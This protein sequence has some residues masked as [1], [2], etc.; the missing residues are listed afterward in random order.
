MLL[1]RYSAQSV[2]CHTEH[3]VFKVLGLAYKEPWNRNT[4][5]NA[6]ITAPDLALD[7]AATVLPAP[8][9]VPIPTITAPTSTDD[10]PSPSSSSITATTAAT[11]K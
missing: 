1:Y 5:D 11:N 8:A 3:D 4:F 7:P 6:N 10:E 9:P 2:A